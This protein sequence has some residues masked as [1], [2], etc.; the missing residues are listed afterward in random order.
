MHKLLLCR[1]MSDESYL[2]HLWALQSGI[3]L[4][5]EDNS[6]M[7]RRSYLPLITSNYQVSG[8]TRNLSMSVLF[9]WTTSSQLS[10]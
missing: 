6:K 1:A 10:R 2:E 5:R 4:M 9:S 3:K 7:I 8:Q